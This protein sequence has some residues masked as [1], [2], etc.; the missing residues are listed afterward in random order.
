MRDLK[1]G[2]FRLI[3]NRADNRTGNLLRSCP[4]L[5][6]GKGGIQSILRDLQPIEKVVGKRVH[7][8]LPYLRM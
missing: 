5:D 7:G 8:K 3:Q 1:A 6:T 2:G 4:G